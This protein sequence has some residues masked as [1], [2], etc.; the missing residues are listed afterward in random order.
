[1]RGLVGLVLVLAFGPGCAA[2]D[3]TSRGV[4]EI[5]ATDA[6]GDVYVDARDRGSVS[7]IGTIEL[8]AGTHVIEL[9]SENLVLASTTVEIR[10]GDRIQVDLDRN[11]IGEWAGDAAVPA[12]IEIRSEPTSAEAV[13]DGLHAGLTPVHVL[14]APGAHQVAVRAE[15]YEVHEEDVELAAGSSTTLDVSLSPRASSPT[16]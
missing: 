13:V 12:Q 9:R 1:M 8:A 6:I 15:G 4:V 7:S 5:R 14:I 11:A 10:G 2:P 3:A 16:P